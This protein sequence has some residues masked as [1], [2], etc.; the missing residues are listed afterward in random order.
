MKKHKSEDYKISAVQ[1]YIEHNK[2]QTNTC[3]I[4]KCSRRSLIR[5]V[6]RYKNE[7]SIKRHNRKPISYKIKLKHINY[8]KKLVKNNKTITIKELHYLIKNKFSDFNISK[9]HLDKVLDDNHITL[10][11]KRLRPEPLKRYGKNINIKEI[12]NNFYIEVKKYKLDD[13]VCIDETS[14]NSYNTRQYCYSNE[15]KRCIL[16]THNQEVFKKYTGIFAIT[17]KGCI[18][19]KIYEKGGID[20]IRL[21]D[22]LEKNIVNKYKNKLII[23]DNA[24]CHRNKKVKE[25]IN[26][27]NKLLHSVVYQHYTN[28]IE[29]YFSILKNYLYK[30]K[31]LG[32][33]KLNENIKSIIK[34]IPLSIYE[35]IF[36]GSYERNK[37]F[38]IKKHRRIKNKIYKNS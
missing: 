22:F 13:I 4:F 27:N 8:M 23:L 24:S 38:K 25:V 1:Y 35:N 9:R 28:C 20:S 10:K 37:E 29:N 30:K 31:D 6:K 32:Y 18:G 36:K 19:Y 16:K 34:E 7:K 14:L 12:I 17:T 15:G 21:I 11:L 2:S 33:I 3:K 26:K 5:W